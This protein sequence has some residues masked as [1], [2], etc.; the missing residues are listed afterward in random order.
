[1]GFGV[2]GKLPAAWDIVMHTRPRRAAEKRLEK[3]I[4]ADAID[5]D[6]T[7]WPLSKKPHTYFW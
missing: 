3:R 6:D 1:L 7:A 4:L 5:P 2:A